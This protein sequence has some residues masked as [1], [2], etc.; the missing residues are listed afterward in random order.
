MQ[1]LANSDLCELENVLGAGWLHRI[2]ETKQFLFFIDMFN[3][4]P[5]V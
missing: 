4:S 3:H 1:L 2:K 5:E